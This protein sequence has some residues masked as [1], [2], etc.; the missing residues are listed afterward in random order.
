MNTPIPSSLLGNAKYSMTAWFKTSGGN[1]KG[2]I[3]AWGT[4][5]CGNTTN[6]RFDGFSAFSE[7]WWTCD[8]VPQINGGSFNDNQ[9]HFIVSTY[10][11]TDR[12]IYFD[13]VNIGVDNPA[14]PNFQQGPFLI[15]ATINDSALTGSLDNVAVFNRAL[16]SSEIKS[17]YQTH[18]TIPK[19]VA[20]TS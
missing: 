11:G 2:G 9:W 19:N 1:T 15:G 18:S 12:S 20:E 6:L 8:F 7:Y 4:S 3:L 14:H 13:G 17:L 10:N 5:G 16:S